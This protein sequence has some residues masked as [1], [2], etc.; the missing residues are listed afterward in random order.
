MKPPRRTIG[1]PCVPQR[2]YASCVP[3]TSAYGPAYSFD[4][5]TSRPEVATLYASEA[6]VSRTTSAA[7]AIPMRRSQRF[8]NGMGAG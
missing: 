1:V 5:A 4:A 6:S 8:T 2:R 7:S 3:S